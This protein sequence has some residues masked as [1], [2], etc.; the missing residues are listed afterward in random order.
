MEGNKNVCLRE[1]SR[2]INPELDTEDEMKNESSVVENISNSSSSHLK[3]CMKC[4][5][6]IY[7]LLTDYNMLSKSCSYLGVAYG[8]LLTL[9]VT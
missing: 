8:N 2:G 1:Y 7:L 3:R 5:G 9:S 6:C 4:P